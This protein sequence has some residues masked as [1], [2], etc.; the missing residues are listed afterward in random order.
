[1]ASVEETANSRRDRHSG[2][3]PT[4]RL[5]ASYYQQFD[6][7]LTR[8][9]P[10]EGYGGWKSA[11]VELSRSHTA[12]VV[13][14][15]WDCGRREDYP[16]WYRAVEYIPRA[17]A[18]CE[19]VFPPLLGAVRDHGFRLFHVVEGGDYYKK[20]PGY[21]MARELAGDSPPPLEQ[22]K[23]D[24]HLDRLRRFRAENVFVGNRNAE[25][26][27]C[28]SARI[29][30]A[31]QAQPRDDEGI[32]EDGHQLFALCKHFGVNHLVYAGFA[33]NWCL[34]MS[35]GGMLEMSRRG[36][37]CSALRQA[38]TAVEN[39]ETARHELAKE[40]GLWRVALAFG[41]IFN[42]DDFVS[43]IARPAEPEPRENRS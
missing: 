20:H 17:N 3:G 18:I 34:L 21:R 19:Q 14:H 26:V 6:A 41:F 24:P 2:A 31:P 5:P 40:I 12:L 28:G 11:E 33:I 10:A 37:M 27:K 1:M 42:V 13:M 35:P 23:S 36:I 7:D 30:F 29:N 8:D 15:A 32:A 4:L 16:G 25:D 39:K 38:V 9:I 22:V 43:A